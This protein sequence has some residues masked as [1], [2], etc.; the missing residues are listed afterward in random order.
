MRTLEAASLIK[1]LMAIVYDTLISAGLLMIAGFGVFAFNGHHA[2]PPNTLWF[3]IYLVAIVWSYFTLSWWR[4]GQTVG[5]RAW[6]LEVRDLA[7]NVPT[8]GRSALRATVAPL[9]LA[10]AGAG[11][12]WCWFDRDGQSAGDRICGTQLL[13]ERK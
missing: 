8:L 3:Q 11:L 2:V 1:R 12:F 9:T 5:A 4:G 10:L 6:K 7:G 13:Q